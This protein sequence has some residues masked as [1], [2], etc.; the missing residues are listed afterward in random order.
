M[1]LKKNAKFLSIISLILFSVQSL[2]QSGFNPYELFASYPKSTANKFRSANGAPGPEYWQNRVNYRINASIDT[3]T[4]NLIASVEIEYIN[5]SPDT[6]HSLWLQ[7]DQ[8]MYRE[9]SVSN[10][11]R[12]LNGKQF[13]NGYQFT[14]I[15][16][17][18]K[19][20]R[21]RL[22]DV[23]YIVAGTRM[24]IRP[25]TPLAPKET[26]YI[27]I[28]YSYKIP[29]LFGGRTDVFQTQNGKI[30]EIA[31]WY[32]RM[33]VYD[34]LNGWNTLPYIGTGEFYCEYGNFDYTVT[35]PKGM[36]VVG[37]GEVVNEKEVYTPEQLKRLTMAKGSD[38]TVIIRTKEDV[39]SENLSA[40]TNKQKKNETV[41]WHFKMSN[42]RDVAF[43]ASAAYILDAA[44]INL[45][46]GRKALAMSAYPVESNGDGAWSKSTQYLKGTLEYFSEK[47]TPYPY[48]V[49]I[50]EA[51]M[52]GGMEYPGIVFD[53]MGAKGKTLFWVTAHEIGHTWF[54]MVV[55]SNERLHAWMDEGLNT[56]IDVYA[57]D[58]Y[59]HG[60]FAPKRDGEYAPGG[61]NPAD[62]ILPWIR[63]PKSPT[64]F[65]RADL[66]TGKYR[67]PFTYFKPAFGLILL[68]EQILGAERFDY[69]FTTY[70]KNW[71]YKH[72]SP[73]D[74]F[75]TMESESGE[76]LS[77]FWRQWFQN[78]WLFDVAVDSVE[79]NSIAGYSTVYLVNKEKSAYP[80]TVIIKYADGNRDTLDIP[81]EVWYGGANY[82][83]RI[84]HRSS[85][86]SVAIDPDHKL[87]DNDRN[88]NVWPAK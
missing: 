4:D 48:P 30:Y 5:N 37:S 42:S 26:G 8:N 18:K 27:T 28:E 77:W 1:A 13:T 24:Q 57:S 75:R 11:A 46:G 2:A 88:N 53:G 10:F 78:N 15:K 32:P 76:D 33:C 12:G 68:R 83:F 38:K 21:E 47:W 54:P 20:M 22:A 67:H 72:P 65:E 86:V 69:A 49:A 60:E 44:R 23:Q 85:I 71:S 35:V 16:F 63:D 51:G 43:G 81:V 80:L 87:P 14:S 25:T 50:N 61:G 29:G 6:L 58:N 66:I 64:M 39:V 62:E 41:T 73:D 52:A 9:H 34:D 84:N 40:K 7:T 17:S 45:P 74:F 70:I 19:A 79:S 82:S 3:I 56:F 59:N 31:Q 55:G 36:L